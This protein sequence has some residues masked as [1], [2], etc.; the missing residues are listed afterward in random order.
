MEDAVDGLAHIHQRIK[1]PYVSLQ[2]IRGFT[3]LALE[4]R[5]FKSCCLHVSHPVQV[6]VNTQ[7]Q[8]NRTVCEF[9]CSVFFSI[10][11]PCVVCRFASDDTLLKQA[12]R[13]GPTGFSL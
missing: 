13:I 12:D 1:V 6:R 2:K 11:Y 5:K 9:L 4:D 3:S 7:H 10:R 8:V